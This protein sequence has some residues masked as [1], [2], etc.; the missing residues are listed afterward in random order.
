[1]NEKLRKSL[2]VSKNKMQISQQIHQNNQNNASLLAHLDNYI[3]ELTSNQANQ[4][5]SARAGVELERTLELIK[6]LNKGH[7]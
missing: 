2:S 6:Q 4:K 3:N 7:K 5:D 1:M